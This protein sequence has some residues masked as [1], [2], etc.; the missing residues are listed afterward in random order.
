MP[1]ADDLKFLKDSVLGGSGESSPEQRQSVESYAASL[2]DANP[3]YL[4]DLLRAWIDKVARHAYKTTDDDV[5]N[6]KADGYSEDQIFEL[7]IA[8]ALGA[9]RVR[10]ECALS[11]IKEEGASS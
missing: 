7:T 5:Q 6:L 11:A 10:L 1:F 2:S 3:Q 9:L 4:P 8:A